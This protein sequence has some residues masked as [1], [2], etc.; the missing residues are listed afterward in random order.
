M[1]S[2]N[3]FFKDEDRLIAEIKRYLKYSQN[4]DDPDIDGQILSAIEIIKKKSAPMY[5][6]KMFPVIIK[7]EI[8]EIMIEHTNLTINSKNLTKFL[9]NSHEIAILAATLGLEIDRRIKEYSF[10]NLTFMLIFDA[11]ASAMIEFVCDYA[12]K[13]LRENL[14]KLG[15]FVSPR[16]SPGY[17]DLSLSIQPA[18]LNLINAT[19]SIGLQTSDTFQLIPSKSVSAFLGIGEKTYPLF[20]TSEHQYDHLVKVIDGCKKCLHY[21]RCYYRKT[22]EYCEFQRNLVG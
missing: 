6:L 3:D 10:S 9:K 13:Q 16:F 17:G 20:T 11:T 2:T 12:E 5:L 21:E 18:L 19:K 4:F 22:G 7:E 14:S 1:L 15:L 8:H